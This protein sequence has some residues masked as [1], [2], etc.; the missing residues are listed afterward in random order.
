[1][2]FFPKRTSGFPYNWDTDSTSQRIRSVAVSFLHHAEPW[3][4]HTGNTKQMIF[5][6]P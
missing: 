5:V 4:W 2:I 1:M 6:I 3:A